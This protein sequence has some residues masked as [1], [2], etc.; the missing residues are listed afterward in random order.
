MSSPPACGR[1]PSSTPTFRMCLTAASRSDD[2]EARPST[3]STSPTRST[4]PTSDGR[5]RWSLIAPSASCRRS[6]RTPSVIRS[7][8][9]TP[10]SS[11]FWRPGRRSARRR[12]G[13]EE[14]QEEPDPTRAAGGRAGQPNIE[15]QRLEV[16]R[17]AAEFALADAE[18]QLRSDLRALGALLKIPPAEAERWPCGGRSMTRRSRPHRSMTCCA[19]PWYRA[20][21]RGLSTRRWA[22]RG[23]RGPGRGESLPGPLLPVSALHVP[24]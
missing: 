4:S 12:K 21:P 24:G 8:T 13:V 3:I 22:G 9:S 17:E 2:R 15:D 7:T 11:R 1:I 20:G 23:R 16:Q 10:S 14:L 6:S 19:W 18:E 5:G